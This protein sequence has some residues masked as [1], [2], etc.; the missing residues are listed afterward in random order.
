MTHAAAHPHKV[1]PDEVDHIAMQAAAIAT[2]AS[3]VVGF[4]I[5]II[6]SIIAIALPL[7]P[8]LME[9]CGGVKATKTVASNHFD[10][11]SQEFDSRAIKTVRPELRRA[12]RIHNRQAIEDGRLSDVVHPSKSD[13]DG[14]AVEMLRQAKDE[15][16]EAVSACMAAAAKMPV[17]SDDDE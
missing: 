13:L 3:A 4:S 11:A 6:A 8:K 17:E 10:E 16:K 14:M 9:L 7:V 5:E 12:T 15:P 1:K 2:R